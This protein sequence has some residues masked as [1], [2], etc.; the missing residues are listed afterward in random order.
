MLQTT[1]CLHLRDACKHVDVS[2]LQAYARCCPGL[3]QQQQLHAVISQVLLKKFHAQLIAAAI[4]NQRA[5]S[6]MCMGTLLVLT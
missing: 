5:A 6:S 1:G 2:Q 4:S 3:T